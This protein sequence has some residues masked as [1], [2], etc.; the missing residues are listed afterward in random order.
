M[1]KLKGLEIY[2]YNEYMST[3]Q[4]PPRRRIP[5]TEKTVALYLE[6]KE[7]WP[8]GERTPESVQAMRDFFNEQ[9]EN[10]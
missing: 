8:S 1:K 10:H 5:R 4:L 2:D 7:R 9:M 3:C 6:M